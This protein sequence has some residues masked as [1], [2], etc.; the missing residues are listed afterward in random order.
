MKYVPL[1]F[2]PCITLGISDMVCS[3]DL[4]N[5]RRQ[6][7]FCC[8]VHVCC[9]GGPYLK[10]SG[11]SLCFLCCFFVEKFGHLV[12]MLPLAKLAHGPKEEDTHNFEAH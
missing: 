10:Y 2:P 11:C 4:R 6:F 8:H 5:K 3:K 12:K 9:L 7:W 1:T